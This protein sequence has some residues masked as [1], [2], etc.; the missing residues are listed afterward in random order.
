MQQSTLNLAVPAWSATVTRHRRF[1][2]LFLAAVVVGLAVGVLLLWPRPSAISPENCERIQNGMTLAD[3][4]AFLGGPPGTYTTDGQDWSMGMLDNGVRSITHTRRVWVGDN[5]GIRI[6]FDEHGHV[7]VC[8]W[9]P[10]GESLLNRM[11]R[12]LRQ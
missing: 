12:W 6:D 1:L 8:Q 10:R 9:C 2:F 5:G 11:R 3:V 4:E 7:A